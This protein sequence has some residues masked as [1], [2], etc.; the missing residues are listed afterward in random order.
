MPVLLLCWQPKHSKWDSV[1]GI[2]FSVTTGLFP[3]LAITVCTSKCWR[4]DQGRQEDMR[5][6]S[7]SAN[8]KT[9]VW[10]PWTSLRFVNE[11]CNPKRNADNLCELRKPGHVT[12]KEQTNV[13]RFGTCK[14]HA[15]TWWDIMK[16]WRT[17]C[18]RASA[19]TGKPNKILALVCYCYKCCCSSLEQ[20]AWICQN[21][22]C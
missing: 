2:R 21:A 3:H 19:T 12:Y 7:N 6:I 8:Q 20:N 18:L 11:R 15:C 9:R 4:H 22:F 5:A 1:F 17:S 10:L 13:E 14:N 16:S